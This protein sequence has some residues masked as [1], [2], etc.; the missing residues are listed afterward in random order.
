MTHDRDVER[1]DAAARR[2]R[3]L[4]WWHETGRKQ[5]EQNQG[6]EGDDGHSD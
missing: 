6:E 2:R 1:F 5:F 4:D 3:R